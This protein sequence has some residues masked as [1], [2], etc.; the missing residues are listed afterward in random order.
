MPKSPGQILKNK[1]GYKI[2]GSLWI[3]FKG[4]RFFGP[5]PVEL[6]LLIRETGSIRQAAKKMEMSYQKA[7]AIIKTLNGQSSQPLV[8]VQSGGKKGGGT[9]LTADALELISYYTQLRKRFD[10]FLQNETKRMEAG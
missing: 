8:I 5:G 3:E 10:S 6:L 2:N 9:E 1:S 4:L 7:W